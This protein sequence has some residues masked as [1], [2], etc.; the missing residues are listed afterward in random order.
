[1]GSGERFLVVSILTLVLAIVAV[2]VL[3]DFFVRF[4]VL[5]VTR[6]FY[7]VRPSGLENIPVEGGALIVPNHV[8]FVDSLIISAT[9]QRR[10]R[11]VMFRGIYEKSILKPLFKLMRVIPISGADKPRQMV[12]SIRAAQ[13]CLKD[14][15]LVCIFAEGALTINGNMHA[16]RPGFEKIVK[17]TGCPVI[18]A[19]LGN[20]WGSIFSR[21]HGKILGGL[22]SHIPY[23]IDVVYGKQMDQEASAYEIRRAV[24][25]LSCD[26]W[27]SKH[28]KG[29]NLGR[30]FA[31]NARRNWFRKA[32]AD[33]TGKDLSFG[34][35]L[36]GSLVLREKLKA[37]A[38]GRMVGVL[39]PSSVGGAL[40]NL[41]LTLD[42]RVP[43]NLNFTASRE[44]IESAV[45]QCEMKSVVSSRAFVA[46]MSGMY[47]PE[48]VIY[49]E[50]IM[51]DVSSADRIKALLKAI[52]VPAGILS[53]GG[54]VGSEDLATIIFS[55]GSTGEPKGVMLTHHNI[56]SNI[57]AFQAVVRFTKDDGMCAILP[58]FHSFGFTTTLWCPALKGFR[59][60]YHANPIDGGKIAEI[61]REHALTV[62]LSTPS[63]LLAYMRRAKREDF[64]SLRLVVA[65][66][67]KLKKKIA[68]RFEE[69]FGIRPL[70]G[71][72]ATELSPVVSINLPEVRR[73][74]VVQ[75][76]GKEG[77]VG[78]PL[79]G[80]ATK[81]VDPDTGELLGENEAGLLLVKGPNVMQGY[82][83][84]TEKTD[85]VLKD[86]WYVTGDIVMVDQDGFI[87][88]RDRLSR[89]SKIAGEMVPH[90]G[91]E[92]KISAELEAQNQAVFV[93]SAPDEKK[94]EQLVLFY[95][96]E[97][98]S[99][100]GLRDAIEKA[101][102]P[103]LWK[104]KKDNIVRIEEVPQLGS[105]KLDLKELKRMAAEHVENKP[106]IVRKAVESI[107]EVFKK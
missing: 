5:V 63:F 52:F 51:K 83:G 72:G 84:S 49:L 104:P 22:P 90:L 94:G 47:V 70:E 66:A 100:E 14:G 79:P 61:V 9:T 40:T 101:D 102:M 71:Y 54:R 56:I 80:L 32:F 33:T 26:Y 57:E 103:N 78:H 76:G 28:C 86:G 43:V 97:A 92:D 10:V 29:R 99:L 7:R 95:T 4:M 19:Y 8:T 96:D 81:V 27:N 65:G 2:M 89:Y 21:Y 30:L 17:G 106:G 16:F 45:R 11:F 59:V 24:M 41:A 34:K 39:L 68:D 25:E 105:G 60:H 44:A 18:P 74:D 1:M 93:S 31:R 69:R 73:G 58:L 98:G 36:I 50:D 107:K 87:F 42:G 82:L 6:L 77:S 46:K 38:E 55:S 15:Y 20:A 13:Q 62:L 67:E 12:E 37:L 48:G 75:A 35:T 64:E 91:V 53:A 88:I 3:P 23:P 85:E